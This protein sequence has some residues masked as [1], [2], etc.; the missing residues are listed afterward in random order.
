MHWVV[1]LPPLVWVHGGQTLCVIVPMFTHGGR[2]LVGC[3]RCM[4][5]HEPSAQPAAQPAECSATA[6]AILIVIKC[7]ALPELAVM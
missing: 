3:A 2:F 6:P 4:V 5:V 7:C 1:H